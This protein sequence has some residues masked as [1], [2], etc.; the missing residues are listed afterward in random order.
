MIKECLLFMLVYLIKKQPAL[1]ENLLD[2]MKDHVH[3]LGNQIL[4]EALHE[5]ENSK[6]EYPF[7]D[8]I[9]A[10]HKALLEEYNKRCGIRP[11]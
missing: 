3:L 4:M 1:L 2:F 10:M 9:N 5:F 11:S 8:K 7:K 6:Q